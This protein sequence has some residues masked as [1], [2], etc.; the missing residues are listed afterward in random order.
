MSYEELSHTA[1]VKIRACA[2]TTD[3]LFSEAFSA[4]MQVMYGGDRQGG[5]TRS[6][7]IGARDLESLLC[8]F[9]SEV[10]YVTEVEGLVFR[11]ADVYLDEMHLHA[12]LDGEPFD[13]VRHNKGTEVKGISYSGMSIR[14]D[15]KGYM[16]D[17]LFDV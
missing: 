2:P 9:L 8:D 5:T 16:L 11:Q 17:I 15:A 6:I 7:D 1:D 10:L 14:K 13:P 4:L 12:V 3:A